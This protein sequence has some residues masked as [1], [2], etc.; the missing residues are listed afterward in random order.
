MAAEQGL[1]SIKALSAGGAQGVGRG[2]SWP[3]LTKGTFLTMWHQAQHT[4]LGGRR[5]KWGAVMRFVLP[6]HHYMGWS[7]AF[8]GIAQHLPAQGQQ[9]IN[10]FFLFHIYSQLLL[11]LLNCIYI[12]THKFSQFY[13]SNSLPHP[14]EWGVNEWLCG[15]ELLAGV[16][17]WHIRTATSLVNNSLLL[18]RNKLEIKLFSQDEKE[19]S[20]NFY[21]QFIHINWILSKLRI[22]GA[23]KKK[24]VCEQNC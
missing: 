23:K 19:L 1:H 15:A 9:W 11:Y 13:P 20:S 6:N 16:K 17:P 18:P 8:L 7:P 14:A 12:P 3:Q 2:H 21:I 5:R 10:Y 24:K 22:S 4:G